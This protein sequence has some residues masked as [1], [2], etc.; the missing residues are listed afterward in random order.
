MANGLWLKPRWVDTRASLDSVCAL[1]YGS[2]NRQKRPG[3][4]VRLGNGVNS[5]ILH[6]PKFDFAD[7]SLTVGAALW[8]RLAERCLE[9]EDAD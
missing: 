4:F 8:A 7:E 3:C 2:R 9:Q 1:G 5:A 6:S